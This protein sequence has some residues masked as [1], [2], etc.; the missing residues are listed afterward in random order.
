MGTHTDS[1]VQKH[2][3]VQNPYLCNIIKYW[4]W[5]W[6][7]FKYTPPKNVIL[8]LRNSKF[9]C[10]HLHLLLIAGK[11]SLEKLKGATKLYFTHYYVV[12]IFFNMFICFLVFLS[13]LCF[14]PL[15][16]IWC[17]IL[18]LYNICII[19]VSMSRF[20]VHCDLLETICESRYCIIKIWAQLLMKI[21]ASREPLL[22]F[23]NSICKCETFTNWKNV[24]N[25]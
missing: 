4:V 12:I 17:K 13:L 6:K 24:I 16:R 25:K 19:N 20:Q 9:L 11:G 2:I 3:W 10:F 21:H 1:A 23:K 14:F 5:H 22:S 18:K 7:H 15:C 8:L